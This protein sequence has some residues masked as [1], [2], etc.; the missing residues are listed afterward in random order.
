MAEKDKKRQDLADASA[1]AMGAIAEAL[2]ETD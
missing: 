2:K 1:D